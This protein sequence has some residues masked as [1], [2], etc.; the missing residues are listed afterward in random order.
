MLPINNR[1]F[2][3]LT[4]GF[5]KKVANH[6]Y[7]LAIYYMH[8]T[9]CRVHQALRVN[10]AMQ[11][12]V[13]DQQRGERRSRC[14]RPLSAGR[15]PVAGDESAVHF[16]RRLVQLSYGRSRR[17]CVKCGKPVESFV[18]MRQRFHGE[19]GLLCLACTNIW[20]PSHVATAE[21]LESHWNAPERKP[22]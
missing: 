11:A 6:E 18:E 19:A 7:V 2:T 15:Y 3:R 17:A 20:I 1:L 16:V 5:S 4:Y 14:W 12:G 21:A 13:S 8:Y 9:I 10:S 22:E